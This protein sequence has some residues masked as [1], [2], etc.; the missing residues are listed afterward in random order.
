LEDQLKRINRDICLNI[1]NEF[2]NNDTFVNYILK[3][4]NGINGLT[5]EEL[6]TKFNK[7]SNKIVLK[8]FDF[9]YKYDF[10]KFNITTDKIYNQ[11]MGKK[12]ITLIWKDKI[13]DDAPKIENKL[14][15][16]YRDYINDEI[17]SFRD[18]LQRQIKNQFNN[19][20]AEINQ[21]IKEVEKYFDE[22]YQVEKIQIKNTE[23][24]LH[25]IENF[26]KKLDMFNI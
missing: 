21:S 11:S 26:L 23:E 20:K 3:S 15:D 16:I 9:Y 17:Q 25:N 18:D 14:E 7:L 10:G 2:E 6:I 5:I 8:K 19:Y 1:K 22:K 12:L 4:K 13:G 24:T